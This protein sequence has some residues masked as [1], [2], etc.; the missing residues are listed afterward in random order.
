M[1]NFH[2][3]RRGVFPFRHYTRG[4][5]GTIFHR[6]YSLLY[7]IYQ[8]HMETDS[9]TPESNSAAVSV[10]ARFLVMCLCVMSDGLSESMC[11][12]EFLFFVDQ[13]V[14]L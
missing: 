10:H 7:F 8:S 11:L 5:G 2:T 13:S 9:V 4:A 1:T 3:T 14:P 12:C 6:L